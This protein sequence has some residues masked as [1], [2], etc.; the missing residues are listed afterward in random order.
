MM[1]IYMIFMYKLYLNICK[2]EKSLL[3][4]IYMYIT[5]GD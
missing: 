3:F 2:L 5:A 4:F 1:L